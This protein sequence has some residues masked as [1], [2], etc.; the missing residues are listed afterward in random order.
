MRGAVSGADTLGDRGTT[1][2][3]FVGEKYLEEAGW[4][5]PIFCTC[6]GE[7]IV[8]RCLGRDPSAAESNQRLPGQKVPGPGTEHTNAG[9]RFLFP[10]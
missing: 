1:S 7:A 2:I 5:L 9:G 4:V 6:P 8:I 10:W 3:V